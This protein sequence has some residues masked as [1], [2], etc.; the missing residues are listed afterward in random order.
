MQDND[1]VSK[2]CIMLLL[3][4]AVEHVGVLLNRVA[5]GVLAAE[6]VSLVLGSC[7]WPSLVDHKLLDL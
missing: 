1:Y 6:S 5:M 3:R 4:D 2:D 7:F